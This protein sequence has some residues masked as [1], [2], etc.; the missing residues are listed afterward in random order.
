MFNVHRQVRNRH[1][2]GKDAQSKLFVYLSP[3]GKM[4]AR[5]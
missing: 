2:T 4:I 1:A 3:N 5:L